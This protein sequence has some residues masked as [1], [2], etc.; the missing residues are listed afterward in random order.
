MV[1][2]KMVSASDLFQVLNS[3]L[4][5]VFL[6]VITAVHLLVGGKSRSTVYHLTAPLNLMRERKKK[7]PLK[8]NEGNRI[9]FATSLKMMVF[10][11]LY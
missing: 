3:F 8:H 4:T 7:S 5:S 10:I 9:L 11:F 2:K 1:S 6:S